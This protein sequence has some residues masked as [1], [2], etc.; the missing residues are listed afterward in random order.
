LRSPEIVGGILGPLGKTKEGSAA[1]SEDPLL[2]R[3]TAATDERQLSQNT[4]TAY[5]R[6]WLKAI[7]WAAAEGL[8]LEVLPSER[9]GEF[10]EEATRPHH[11]PHRSAR[12]GAHQVHWRLRLAVRTAQIG[13]SALRN[14]RSA[15]LDAA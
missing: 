5:R 10:Y 6:T 2:E 4:L 11:I 3:I 15:V 9:V 7:V 1:V 13:V 14:L 8:A 12:L